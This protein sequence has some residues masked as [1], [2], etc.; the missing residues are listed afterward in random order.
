MSISP[1][2]LVVKETTAGLVFLK[3]KN[4]AVLIPTLPKYSSVV[5]AKETEPLVVT[6]NSGSTGPAGAVGPAGPRGERGEKGEGGDLHF[7]YNQGS[8]SA[9][10]EIEHNLGKYPS[11]MAEDT[12]GEDI[13]GTV[14]YISINK[15]NVV[16]SAA[17]GG[18]AYLN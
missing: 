7:K 17:T 1:P 10:W 13:E 8:A 4:S 14:E 5:I 16:Y 2:T 6:V 18:V 12:A 11:V 3:E 9:L 15:L